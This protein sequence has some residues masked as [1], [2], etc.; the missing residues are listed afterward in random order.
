MLKLNYCFYAECSLLAFSILQALLKFCKKHFE[1]IFPW[2]LPDIFTWFISN[3]SFFV[4]IAFVSDICSND[5][6]NYFFLS[7]NLIFCITLVRILMR[8]FL[9]LQW[10]CEMFEKR[11]VSNKQVKPFRRPYPLL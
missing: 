3:F 6:P 7:F 10:L 1:S 11:N 8:T 2:V 4:Y 5:R 9:T